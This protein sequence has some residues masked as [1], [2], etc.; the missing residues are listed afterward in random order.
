MKL[1]FTYDFNILLSI[2]FNDIIIL[3]PCPPQNENHG[4]TKYVNVNNYIDDHH[5]ITNDY[6]NLH[7]DPYQIC[8][9][10]GQRFS[11]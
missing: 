11:P 8:G 2:K 10:R 3:F 9:S 4:G 1:N 6:N 7:Y 5:V